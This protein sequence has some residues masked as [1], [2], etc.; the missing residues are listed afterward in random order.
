MK[1]RHN[2]YKY[3]A[4]INKKSQSD[5]FKLNVSFNSDH[6]QVKWYSY[7]K[8]GYYNLCVTIGVS[9]DP[10]SH[11]ESVGAGW[12]KGMTWSHNLKAHETE[13]PQQ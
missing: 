8:Q 2:R 1:T 11:E 13:R 7:Y 5:T 9:F 4:V 6:V 10:V 12:D 3:N